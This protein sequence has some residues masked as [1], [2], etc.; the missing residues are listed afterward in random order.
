MI[1]LRLDGLRDSIAIDFDRMGLGRLASHSID[2][3]V[4]DV[5]R[6]LVVSSYGRI[7]RR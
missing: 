7:R 1:R 5:A 2:V 6:R 3:L 4:G